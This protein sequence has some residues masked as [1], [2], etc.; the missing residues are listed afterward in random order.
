MGNRTALLINCSKMEA[1]KIREQAE[2]QRRT[3]SG[4]VMYVV[5]RAVRFGENLIRLKA[6]G[7]DESPYTRVID[8]YGL[9]RVPPKKVDGPRTTMLLWCSKDEARRVRTV[10]KKRGM[11]ISGLVL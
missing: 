7:F 6:L 10:A 11:T 8:F 2:L 4:Y 3:I 9:N 1:Q 5:V